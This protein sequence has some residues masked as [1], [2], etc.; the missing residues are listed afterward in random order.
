VH[1]N[2]ALRVLNGLENHLIMSSLNALPESLSY[3]LRPT[4]PN[5]Q[6]LIKRN[7]ALQM[8]EIFSYFC[9]TVLWLRNFDTIGKTCATLN[10]TT[11]TWHHL[12]RAI[13]ILLQRILWPPGLDDDTYML[14][15]EGWRT[16]YQLC[17]KRLPLAFLPPKWTPATADV[18][19]PAAVLLLLFHYWGSVP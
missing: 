6:I 13:K 5:L 9:T 19:P 17:H 2:Y 15:D 14:W 11:S 8:T 12:G 10:P 18:T 7:E 3:I 4:L 1:V 16:F